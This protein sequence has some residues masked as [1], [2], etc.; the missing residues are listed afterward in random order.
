MQDKR[1]S[2]DPQSSTDKKQAENIPQLLSHDTFMK[3]EG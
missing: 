1:R 3:K 2:L